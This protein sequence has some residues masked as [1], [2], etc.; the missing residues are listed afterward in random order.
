MHARSYLSDKEYDGPRD[1]AGLVDTALTDA[2]L[3]RAVASA[4]VVVV[5]VDH[6]VVD[7]VESGVLKADVFHG[8]GP[9]SQPVAV[10]AVELQNAHDTT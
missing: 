1:E 3:H 2:L 9:L 6:A 4:M 8:V 10:P 7:L 5:L